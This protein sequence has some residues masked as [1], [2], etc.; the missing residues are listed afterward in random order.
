MD[1][2]H[3]PVA[4]L[5]DQIFMAHCLCGALIFFWCKVVLDMVKMV[6]SLGLLQPFCLSNNGVDEVVYTSRLLCVCP[7]IVLVK[8][9]ISV[10]P[11][12][13]HHSHSWNDRHLCL[14]LVLT[15]WI[16]L[17]IS[18]CRGQF[19]SLSYQLTLLTFKSC[20]AFFILCPKINH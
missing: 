10:Y 7:V 9:I 8:I 12:C 17:T 11:A 19:T 6:Q 4:R 3:S 15:G 16:P 13:P 20:F 5:Q 18:S 2:V 14:T 1:I